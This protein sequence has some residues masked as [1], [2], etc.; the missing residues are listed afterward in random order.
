MGT[1]DR[2]EKK[3]EN[4]VNNVFAKA[5]RS[6]VKPVEI[7]SAIRRDMD[8]RA[9]AVSRDRTVVPNEFTVRL[10]PSDRERVDDWGADALAE[11]MVAAATAHA[12]SQ[13]YA[14]VGPVR[15]HFETDE[16]VSTGRLGVTSATRRG[17]TAPATSTAASTRHP[18]IDIDGQRYLLT[19]PVTVLGRGTEAD[20][21]VDDTGVSRRHLE[22]RVTPAGTVA[23]DLGSTNG[24]FV[25]GHRVQ[26][27]TLLDGNTITIGRTRIMFWNGAADDEGG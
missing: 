10:S 27:A 11:E 23:T 3:V 18:I 5:F 19:G 4:A 2:F 17:S 8:D 15:V 14:F 20:V 22:L 7:A 25:E 12:D 6:E 24:T 9:A 16:S 21:V 13:H 1:L 26:A